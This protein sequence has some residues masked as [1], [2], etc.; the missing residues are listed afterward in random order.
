MARGQ[1]VLALPADEAIQR[2]DEIEEA[3]LAGT[4]ESEEDHI[5]RKRRKD[6]R[7]AWGRM[8]VRE[9]ELR[10]LTATQVSRRHTS[11]DDSILDRDQQRRDWQMRARRGRKY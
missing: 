4:S 6:V 3:Y 7:K 11:E 10:R 5:E 8:R 9:R 1:I 2:L